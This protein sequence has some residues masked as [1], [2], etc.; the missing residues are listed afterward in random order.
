[1]II[2]K[3]IA[4]PHALMACL[5]LL[6]L[7]ASNARDVTVTIQNLSPSGGVLLTPFWLGVH[8]GSFD[9][10]DRGVAASMALER[11]A[12]DGSTGPLSDAFTASGAGGHQTTLLGP[13]IPPIAP[14]QSASH[15]FTLD[16]G[17]AS[18][19]YFSYA[20]MVI[21]S[22]DAFVANGNPVAHPLFDAAGN[23]LSADILRL[24]NHVLDAGTEINDELPATTAFLGQAAPNTGPAQN[25][26]VELHS[27]FNPVGTGG[28][29]DGSFLGFSFGNADFTGQGY[30]LAR[31]TVTSSQVPDGGGT[32]AFAGLVLGGLGFFA[33]SR[34]R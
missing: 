11:L 26:V 29:L 25:G 19:R 16:P 17:S 3:Q 32:L 18:D 12:E 33:R 13:V 28:I 34:N 1:M 8:D 27:G 9:L 30:S 20:S 14:G 4:H 15:V 23:F 31:I 5:G 10:Y 21:P 2:Q 24:G 6:C 22:N 7:T